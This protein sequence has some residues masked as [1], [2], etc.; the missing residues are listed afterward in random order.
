MIFQLLA[1]KTQ[2]G[3]TNMPFLIWQ[4]AE[5]K[6]K[7]IARVTGWLS[8]DVISKCNKTV[9]TLLLKQGNHSKHKQE[10]GRLINIMML[11]REISPMQ[12]TLKL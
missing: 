1:L 3:F 7:E 10:K 9:K 11:T 8:K 12:E 5:N 6:I 2:Y 4:G